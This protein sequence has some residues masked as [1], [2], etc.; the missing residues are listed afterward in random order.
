[1]STKVPKTTN[2]PITTTKLCIAITGIVSESIENGL[3]VIKIT[4][5]SFKKFNRWLNLE[6]SI[7]I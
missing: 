6:P 4:P 3:M 1:M 7:I 2:N 5:L